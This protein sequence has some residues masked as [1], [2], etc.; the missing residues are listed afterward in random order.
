MSLIERSVRQPV[1][2]TVGVLLVVIFGAL[3]L[4]DIYKFLKLPIQ[5]TPNVDQ[6]EI[7]VTTRW[8][9]ASPQEIENEIIDEQ[10]QVLKTV[11][12]LREMV[13]SSQ[14]GEGTITLRFYVGVD[15]EA[16]LNEVRDKLRQVP[17]YPQDVEEP[18]VESV[19]AGSDNYIAWIMVRP[20]GDEAFLAE[21]ARRANIPGY[22]GRVIQLQDFLEEDVKPMLERVEGIAEVRVL[23]GSPR[24]MQV[25][26]DL[27][28]LAARGIS[29]TQFNDALRRQ[30]LNVTA[31]TMDQGKSR[32]SVR[33]VGQYEDPETIRSTVIAYSPA[34][35]PIYVRDLADVEL[36]FKKTSWF[37][38]SIGQEIIAIAAKRETGTNILTVMAGLRQAIAQVNRD[39]LDARGVG[40][41]LEQVY[42]ES[43]YVQRSLANARKD[44][45]LGAILAAGVLFLALRSVGAT[46]AIAISIPISILGT[47]LGMALAGRNLNV[48]SMAGLTFSV[49]I[50]IDN[51]IVVLENIFRHREMGKDRIAAAIDGAREVWGAIIASI[52]TNVAVFVPMLFIEEEAGQLFR[53]IAVAITISMGLYL[54]VSPTVVPMLAA[55]FLRKLPGGFDIEGKTGEAQTLLGRLTRP[56]ARGGAQL[57]EMFHAVVYWLTG[58]LARRLVLVLA[59]VVASTIAAWVLT[60][61]STYLPPGNQNLVFAFIAPPPGYNLD[62]FRSMARTVE[63]RLR[64]WWQA[65]PGSPELGLLQ[66]GWKQ[67]VQTQILPQMQ[68]QVAGME[69]AL[70]QMRQRL[71]QMRSSLPPAPFDQQSVQLRENI[72]SLEQRIAQTRQQMQRLASAPPP[73]AIQQFFFVTFFGRAFMGASS[74]DPDIVEP[75]VDLMNDA[76]QGIPGTFGLAQQAPIFR[77]GRLGGG[78]GNIEINVSGTDYESVRQAAGALQGALMARFATFIRPEPLNYNL[79][80]PETQILID[81]V[82]AASAG[83][84]A[85]AIF[86]MSKVALDGSIIGD[87]RLRGQNIDLTV[88]SSNPRQSIAELRDVPLATP[89]G[90]TVPMA[91]V[92]RFVETSAAQQIQRVERRPAV[93]LSVPVSTGQTV[94]EV[95]R[96]INEDVLQPLRQQGALPPEVATAL[97][98]SA[99]KL[100]EFRAAFKPGF[101]LAAVV[102]FLLLAAL[103]ESW[104]YPF[105][106]IMSVPLA[107]VGGIVGLAML[108]A[109]VPGALLD[110]LTMLGFVI[111]I[112]IIVNNPIL[113]VHQTLNFMRDQGMDARHAIARSTQTRVRPIFMT[114]STTVAATAPLVVLGGAGSE[115]YR[116]L[117]AVVIGGLVC[118]TVFTLLLTPS[119]LSLMFD[120]RAA[121]RRWFGKPPP[122]AG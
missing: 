49:G 88:L 114:V 42:D 19:S 94:D 84:T 41:R 106:I 25:R 77:L 115:L 40:V 70:A 105:V 26:V 57:G 4:L 108:H 52:A 8:F 43:I 110:V 73:P 91:S 39:V 14:E 46:L 63:G 15:K 93:T 71:Q 31:G 87:F 28:K 6:P 30:N 117:G 24:E 5:L 23:G 64:P 79:G 118:S 18:I 44:L 33:A 16:A 98:G 38:R 83:I 7:T 67:R 80:R 75:L 11:S 68:Q 27:E 69:A 97:T 34:G 36:G 51:A 101:I 100:D 74:A 58:G 90:K 35:T 113:I 92:T 85:P 112:G 13:S 50:G 121:L 81:H 17:D 66:A 2:V 56:L 122:A 96:I 72:R 32:I 29:I 119:L 22:S 54:A 86:E 12:G 120:L 104:A 60:P 55:L 76:L 3:G 82:Q 116:G 78:G 102:T 48:I 61:D 111:L 21:C 107:L 45:F 9:G 20:Q 37:V 109:F 99:A 103:F 10:E 47:F 59:L 53:D 1:A 62:E 95:K 89:F 65:K